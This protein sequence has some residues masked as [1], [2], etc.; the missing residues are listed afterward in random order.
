[1]LLQ[2][3]RLFDGPIYG[4][5]DVWSAEVDVLGHDLMTDGTPKLAFHAVLQNMTP[6]SD[7]EITIQWEGAV[8][9]GPWRDLTVGSPEVF[10]MAL[11]GDTIYN[12]A[13]AIVMGA[14]TKLRARI[15]CGAS[16]LARARI[17]LVERGKAPR[18][19]PS[20]G[21]E[22]KCRGKCGDS[23]ADESEDLPET[24]PPQPVPSECFRLPCF[25]DNDLSCFGEWECGLD[26]K[27]CTC[28]TDYNCK[29]QG[30]DTFL[31]GIKTACCTN[32]RGHCDQQYCARLEEC[33][34]KLTNKVKCITTA[35]NM[36][37]L[38]K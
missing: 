14:Y 23:K 16:R 20:R 3:A 1:M 7:G 32:A 11:S 15:K 22:C 35:R 13:Q 24:A 33:S 38:C 37:G 6:G 31:S 25:S 12:V 8:E 29:Q 28:G 2:N 34:K 17:S 10:Q 5:P 4:T 27:V 26:F 36:R 18:Q 21:S 19:E 9:G 30:A